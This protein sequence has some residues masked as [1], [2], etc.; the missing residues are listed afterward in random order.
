M[1]AQYLERREAGAL[2]AL[3]ARIFQVQGQTHWGLGVNLARKLLSDANLPQSLKKSMQTMH[4][5][6]LCLPNKTVTHFWPQPPYAP[7]S[8]PLNTL[9]VFAERK[10]AHIGQSFLF[11][12]D[13]DSDMR[14]KTASPKPQ[15]SNQ[16]VKVDTAVA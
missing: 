14:A 7:P 5:P 3:C 1:R 11:L 12:A 15:S 8:K 10:D 16:Q 2:Y 4:G 9:M 6:Q 13:L